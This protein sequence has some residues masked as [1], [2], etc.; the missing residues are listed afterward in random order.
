[1]KY[2]FSKLK[3]ESYKWVFLFKLLFLSIFGLVFNIIVILHFLNAGFG[4]LYQLLIHIIPFTI[5]GILLYGFVTLDGEMW[6]KW[7]YILITILL[8]N[9]L[10][11]FARYF[12]IPIFPDSE[13]ILTAFV[14]MVVSIS[15]TPGPLLFIW[16]YTKVLY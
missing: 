16:L 8:T 3:N 14:I 10:G 1:M 13:P 5:I 2:N 7:D 11:M 12:Y 15:I 6:L 4:M 9:S